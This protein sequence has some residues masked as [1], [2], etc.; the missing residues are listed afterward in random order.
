MYAYIETEVLPLQH[1]WQVQKK[2][3]AIHDLVGKGD[4]LGTVQDKILL[5]YEMVFTQTR[6]SYRE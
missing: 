4:P 6:T 3:K 5:Y 2:Y 1:H